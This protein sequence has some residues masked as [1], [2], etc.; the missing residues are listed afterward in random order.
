MGIGTVAVLRRPRSTRRSCAKP[1]SRCRWRG[2]RPPRPTSTDAHPRRR[3]LRRGPTP[4]TPATGSCRRARRSPGGADG[5]LVWVGPPP[6]AIAAMGDKLAAKAAATSG[7]GA[8]APG[9]EL[10]GDDAACALAAVGRSGTRCSSRPR[11]VV[12]AR[13]CGWSRPTPACARPVDG[14]AG[15]PAAS[16]GN[17]TVFAGALRRR[18]PPHRDPGLRRHPR[19]RRAP[20]RAGVLHPASAPEDRRGGTVARRRPPAPRSAW[21][22]AALALGGAIGYHGVGTVEFLLD[23]QGQFFFLEMNTRLQVEHPVTEMVTGLDLVAAAVARSARGEPLPPHQADVQLDGHAIEVRVYAED[24]AADWLPVG[25]HGRPPL[26]A[27][28]DAVGSARESGSRPGSVVAP[29]YDSLLA[30]VVAHAADPGRG[31]APPGRALRAPVQG[32][33]TNLDYLRER[34]STTRTSR[35][36]HAHRL[37]RHAIPEPAWTI[38]ALP[39]VAPGSTPSARTWPRAALVEQ[40]RRPLRRRWSFAPRVGATSA[41]TV[42]SATRPWTP[43][44]GSQRRSPSTRATTCALPPP[45]RPAVGRH[46]PGGRT[47]GAIQ[48]RGAPTHF[49]AASESNSP[50]SSIGRSTSDSTGPDHH[51]GPR[52][53]ATGHGATPTRPPSR[54]TPRSGSRRFRARIRFPDRAVRRRG[55]WPR[56]A[57]A[58]TGRRG[59]GRRR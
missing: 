33:T 18:R 5:G 29:H 59:R 50:R 22:T 38:P 47:R 35:G 26:G 34:S 2:R 3:G 42:R 31:G 17:G 23:E 57:G 52:R 45:G 27:R 54:R 8:G 49:S 20:G 1:T 10:R 43:L 21:V 25:G 12:A 14:L 11:P 30:K 39:A 44:D 48:R 51:R 36:R 32:V 37:R 6:D 9:V 15:R 58:R 56:G 19:K 7:R 16:F 55:W 41:S 4:C 24:P 46:R 13:A 28:P 40:G 53:P